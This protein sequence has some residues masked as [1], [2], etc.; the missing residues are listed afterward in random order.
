MGGWFEYNLVKNQE[1]RFYSKVALFKEPVQPPVIK[2]FYAQNLHEHQIAKFMTRT[3]VIVFY[4]EQEN[5]LI[6]LYFDICENYK[7]HTHVSWERKHFMETYCC[8]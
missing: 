6:Y 2:L 1:D 3:D 7:F 4:S 8:G 5:C